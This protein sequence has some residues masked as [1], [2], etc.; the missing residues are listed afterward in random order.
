MSWH[1]SFSTTSAALGHRALVY[2]TRGEPTSVLRAVTFPTLPPPLPGTLNVRILAAPINPS[3]V[4]VIQGVYPAAPSPANESIQNVAGEAEP[5]FVGGN[6]GVAEVVNLGPE[7]EG[8][9]KGDWGQLS[10]ILPDHSLMFISVDHQ[11]TIRNL[12]FDAQH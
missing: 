1:C 12:E 11:A 5:V 6:E 2:G 9:S 4:N 8:L 7:V 10:C 3:D